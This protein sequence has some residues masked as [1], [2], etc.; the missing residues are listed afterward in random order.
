MNPDLKDIA[1]F[2]ET[3]AAEA[4]AAE[5]TLAAYA[6]DLKDVSFWCSKRSKSLKALK[7][8]DI[9]NYLKDLNSDGLAPATR[10]RR[11]SAIKQFFK[12]CFDR[13]LSCNFR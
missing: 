7:R 1:I 13:H 3:K 2:L 10:A 6:R 4:G 5:N 11:L 12:F 9:E 8:E